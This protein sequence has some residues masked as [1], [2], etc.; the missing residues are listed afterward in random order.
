VGLTYDPPAVAL[1]RYRSEADMARFPC[2]RCGQ[3]YR[4][5]QQTAYPAVVTPSVTYSSKLRLCPGCFDEVIYSPAWALADKDDFGITAPC[6]I[7]G[8]PETPVAIFCTY[9]EAHQERRDLYGRLCSGPCLTNFS[10][11]VWG[12]SEGVQ[13]ALKV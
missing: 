1:G 4:G 7:C 3:L 13:A 12:S 9:Y 10:E 6:G 8:K 2:S 11:R 5:P